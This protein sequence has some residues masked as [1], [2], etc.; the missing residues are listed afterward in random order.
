[1]STKLLLDLMVFTT[2]DVM[3]LPNIN[4]RAQAASYARRLGLHKVAPLD[5]DS[6]QPDSNTVEFVALSLCIT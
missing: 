6:H 3:A 2:L 4:S 1:M 5:G